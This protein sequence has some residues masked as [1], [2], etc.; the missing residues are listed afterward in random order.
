MIST[1]NM[2]VFNSNNILTVQEKLIG[3]WKMGLLIQF[4][5]TL[6]ELIND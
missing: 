4:E 2:V 5:G 1:C 6:E 3:P